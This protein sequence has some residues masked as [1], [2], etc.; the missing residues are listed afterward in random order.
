MLRVAK[1]LLF[2]DTLFPET[3]TLTGDYYLQVHF[4]RFWDYYDFTGMIFCHFMC[5]QDN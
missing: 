3:G 1:S 2:L 5:E 4:L